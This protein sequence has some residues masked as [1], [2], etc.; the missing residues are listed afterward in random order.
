MDAN[1]EGLQLA[2]APGGNK[3]KQI[4]PLTWDEDGQP[5]SALFDDPF[6]SRTD[7][8]AETR[9]VFL[10]G[11]GLPGAWAGAAYFSI[12]ELGFGT[13]LNFLEKS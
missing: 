13:G 3:G 9:H 5:V 7:G 12:A 8:A 6:C 4:H 1:G 2:Q 10:K 11:N